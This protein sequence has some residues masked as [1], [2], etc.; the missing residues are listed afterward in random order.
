MT[1]KKL[2]TLVLITLALAVSLTFGLMGNHSARA[3]TNIISAGAAATSAA[4]LSAQFVL[5]T[6]Y[7]IDFNSVLYA[8]PQ[9]ST[10][11]NTVG[12]ISPINGTR[13]IGIDFRPNDGQLYALTDVGSLYTVNL[14]NANATLVSNL[15][16]AFPGGLRSLMDFNPVV[17]AIRL[18]AADGN[19]NYAVVKGANNVLNTVAVQ[20][21]VA[22]AAGDVFA[23][24]EA[25][26]PGGS[27]TNNFAGA[28]TTLFYAFDYV[29]DRMVTIA[30]KANGSSAT[31][32]GQL[33]TIGVVFA[34][35]QQIDFAPMDDL[36]IITRRDLG[37]LNL[38]YTLSS[39]RL[40]F[41][42]L[43]QINPNLQLGQTQNL[44]GYSM[45]ITFAAGPVTPVDVAFPIP[46]T[47]Q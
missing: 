21:S 19:E 1:K 40:L 11:F 43:S 47:Q 4:S 9:G 20:T 33:Q 18:I 15:N 10:T 42:V 39:T 14:T 12:T 6:T 7:A 13:V 44:G 31:G 8:M 5:G 3:K 22:Y 32:G 17:D 26:I 2:T 27:Y 45:P 37:G 46:T 30:N 41:I 36:D 34:N 38:A 23:G 29:T 35:G 16:P 24:T 25:N 28:Q